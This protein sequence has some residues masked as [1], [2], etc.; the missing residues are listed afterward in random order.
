MYNNPNTI[1]IGTT[2]INLYAKWEMNAP[3]FTTT[4]TNQSCPVNDAVTFSV[5]ATGV[6]ISYSW[7]LNGV[8]IS[9]QTGSS[10]TTSNLTKDEISTS[11]TYTCIV[12]NSADSVDC[13]ATLSVSTVTDASNNI[14]HE[15][16][17]V[18]RI[19]MM[20]N[21]KTTKYR[22][23]SS[24]AQV[25]QG[26]PWLLHQTTGAYCWRENDIADKVYGAIYNWAAVET[27]KLPPAGWRIASEADWTALFNA[28][29]PCEIRTEDPQYW[30]YDGC[31]TTP[32]ADFCGFNAMQLGMLAT[33][34]VNYVQSNSSIYWW[35][36]EGDF[37][38]SQHSMS[39]FNQIYKDYP[40]PGAG[41]RCV[42]E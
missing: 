6:N 15:I 5:V 14:Y 27:G 11:R 26:E 19:W 16:K 30:A 4:I 9:G 37:A 34:G 23:G 7:K 20:E 33:D 17:L 35:I 31:L 42:K 28:Y 40:V 18:N 32:R 13:S 1:Q 25:L 10:Y 24:I 29:D 21:L 36:S 12:T 38:V 8:T 39:T 22:D 41:I 2:A 3:S